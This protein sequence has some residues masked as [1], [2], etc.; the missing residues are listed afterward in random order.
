MSEPMQ[1]WVITGPAGSGKSSLSA[2]LAVRGAAVV[3]ADAIGHKLLCLPDVRREVREAFGD[4]VML[5]DRV[6]RAALGSLVFAEASALTRLNALVHPRLAAAIKEDLDAI[7]RAGQ[8]DLAVLEAAVYFLLPSLGKVDLVIAVVASEEVRR[9]RLA[10]L[11]RWTESELS[12]RL[13]AQ[14]PW[15]SFWPRADITL[16]N[17]GTPEDFERAAARALHQRWRGWRTAC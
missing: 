4:R 8:T 5:D 1:R 15:Q 11:E 7:A 9:E 12:R 6:D 16:V 10:R 13:A 2:L 3:N 14:R 17:E